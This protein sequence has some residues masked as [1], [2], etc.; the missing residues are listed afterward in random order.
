[1]GLSTQIL[2]GSTLLAFCALVHVAVVALSIPFFQRLAH[3]L[4]GVRKPRHNAVLL[5]AGIMALLLAH[6]IQIW[7]WAATFFG[8]GAFDTFE[9]SFYFAVVTYTTV[10]YG[11]VTLG[12]GLRIFA[13][14]A[15][16][17]GLLTFGISTAF[18]F[19]LVVRLL[20][21]VFLSGMDDDARI[22]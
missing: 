14:F 11:D 5:T 16:I 2:M 8:I 10:G 12:N 9:E 13:T 20:P 22:D 3:A 4:P 15:S 7:S 18:L 17:T 19:G 1:M 6:T 21:D